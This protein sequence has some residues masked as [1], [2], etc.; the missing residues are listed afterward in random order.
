[1]ESKTNLAKKDLC[2]FVSFRFEQRG[3]TMTVSRVA[4]VDRLFDRT[5]VSCAIIGIREDGSEELLRQK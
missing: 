4:D 2:E 3:F 5:A 1:M